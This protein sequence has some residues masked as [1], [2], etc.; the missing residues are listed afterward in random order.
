MANWRLIPS[1]APTNEL[2]D[3]CQGSILA[4]LLTQRGIKD[5][6]TARGFLNPIHYTPCHATDLIGVDKAVRVLTGH[7]N[8]QHP[9]LVWGDF[10]ADGQTSTSLL[11]AA[12]R[13]LAANPDLILWHIPHRVRDNH[14]VQPEVLTELLARSSP[15]PTL[16]IT[17]DTGIDAVAGLRTARQA[18]LDVIITDHHALPPEF[19][20][21]EPG[22]DA[23][24]PLSDQ[25]EQVLK[26]GVRCI[27]SA[28]VNPQLLPS[29]HPQ[30]HLPGVGVAFLVAQQ[31]FAE[32]RPDISVDQFLDLVALGIVADMAEQKA[33][34][35]YWLQMGLIQLARTHRVGLQ[36]LLDES[37]KRVSWRSTG[38][39]TEQIAFQ[40]G[41]RLN[42][43]S[44]L[45]SAETSVE[46]LLTE[47]KTRAQDLAA[48]LTRLNIRRR[49]E[50]SN[51]AE[52]TRALMAQRPDHES[53]S[54][55]VIAHRGWHP[56]LLG[57]AAS[58]IVDE[59][60][61]PAIVLTISEQGVARG[62]A[63]SVEGVDIRAAISA[64]SDLLISHGGH[65]GAA[66]L[67]LHLDR[68]EEFRHKIS[69]QVQAQHG[70]GPGPRMVDLELSLE[71][72]NSE[73]FDQLEAIEP[74]GVGNP[75][76]VLLSR[77]LTPERVSRSRDG[78]HSFFYVRQAGHRFAIQAKW[79]NAPARSDQLLKNP[80]NLLYH[81]S[82][83]T[84]SGPRRF[85]LI[86]R[87]CVPVTEVSATR[88][89]PR[90]MVLPFPV[91]DMRSERLEVLPPD[92]G[93]STLWYAAGAA[94]PVSWISV[95]PCL[96][97]SQDR[98][99]L[100]IWTAPPSRKH[101]IELLVAN[102]WE[103]VAFYGTEPM[104]TPLEVGQVVELFKAKYSQAWAA[105]QESCDAISSNHLET[106][107]QGNGAN[108]TDVA[109]SDQIQERWAGEIGLTREVMQLTR[110]LLQTNGF[111]HVV[112]DFA[113][114][115]PDEFH[116]SKNQEWKKRNSQGLLK[117]LN[118]ALHE[119]K[120]FHALLHREDLTRHFGAMLDQPK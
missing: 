94:L 62:S 40:I 47:D 52:T 54:C 56:G 59:Y 69:E 60:R 68:L 43:V 38:V 42:A 28:I 110:S 6:E 106:S 20:D 5:A 7:L 50:S 8:E 32:L 27:A 89:E 104:G 11:V 21:L 72:L 25:D 13:Q 63:R 93:S 66:G 108:T 57:I 81:L 18:G 79:F 46:L 4:Q 100:L 67:M 92:L 19:D 23:C 70:S 17:C 9:I 61:K 64:C 35:R 107:D 90:S 78:K 53:L 29:N 111:L 71:E 115:G 10:D 24:L 77:H 91:K 31:L 112:E 85:A 51:I 113:Y 118:L 36:A 44:R 83:D 26:W 12:L 95:M 76:P 39:R 58:R 65:A 116:Q 30:R 97:G 120:A 14:G 74:T 105:N 73:T 102:T 48:K 49:D 98:N 88:S 103:S 87:E 1:E 86:V 3:A 96:S 15:V 41:P 45:E 33:D 80:V 55:L 101:L 114:P 82:L 37:L 34:T 109:V 117:Q 16:V 2:L 99:S 84:F 22:S 119:I 75:Q